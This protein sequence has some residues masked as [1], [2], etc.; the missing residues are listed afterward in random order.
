[1]FASISTA[2]HCLGKVLQLCSHIAVHCRPELRQ[3]SSVSCTICIIYLK[4]SSRLIH[5]HQPCPLGQR[6]PVV[7]PLE[8]ELLKT[9]PT[10]Q[11]NSHIINFT[12]AYTLY[13]TDKESEA[14]LFSQSTSAL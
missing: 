9:K 13:P 12:S 14:I 8:Y 5:H 3:G 11:N 1:M 10:L 4:Q 7:R 2:H 6:V